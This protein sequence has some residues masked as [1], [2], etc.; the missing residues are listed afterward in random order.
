MT[1]ISKYATN[2]TENTYL[3]IIL[4]QLKMENKNLSLSE[5]D[6]RSIIGEERNI[7]YV[8]FVNLVKTNFDYKTEFPSPTK[9]WVA[10]M[11][12]GTAQILCISNT[13][14]TPHIVKHPDVNFTMQEAHAVNISGRNL[15]LS[16][17]VDGNLKLVDDVSLNFDHV[18]K[19]AQKKLIY[20][21]CIPEMFFDEDSVDFGFSF[22]C[23]GKLREFYSIPRLSFLEDADLQHLV[24]EDSGVPHQIFDYWK[25]IT[26]DIYVKY[27]KG[28]FFIL[29]KEE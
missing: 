8:N 20:D 23:K 26:E 3:F 19:Q 24:M 16:T 10:F 14:S 29:R 17:D 21:K 18:S 2:A 15:A 9:A 28:N 27:E 7:L 1:K 25:H 11:E 22:Y 5:K 6:F 4:K 12:D 13:I